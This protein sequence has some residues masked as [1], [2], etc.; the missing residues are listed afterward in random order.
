MEKNYDIFISYR[1]K[2]GAHYARILKAELEKRGYRDRVFLDYD[3]LK[4]GRF[5]RRIMDA[6]VSA[7][8]FI[9]IL[10]PGSLERCI[11]E[12]DWVRQEILYAMEKERHIIP[13]N[14]DGL[15]Q[16]FPLSVPA[17][18]KNALSQHQFTKIDSESLLNVSVDQMIKDRIAPIIA[19]HQLYSKPLGAEIVIIP[20]ADCTIYRLGTLLAKASKDT[21][22]I[23]HLLKGNHM[24]E[25]IS[26]KYPDIKEKVKITVHD[27]DYTDLIEI[28]LKDRVGRQDLE[29]QILFPYKNSVGKWGYASRE[30]KLV[31]PCLYE[32]VGFFT[33]GLASVRI[34]NLG[35]YI[36]KTGKLIIPCMYDYTYPFQGGKARVKK[37]KKYGYIDRMGKMVIPCD[38]TDISLSDTL[39]CVR[40]DGKYG[41]VDNKGYQVMPC[42]YEKVENRGEDLFIV[43]LDG[44][45]GI[46]DRKGNLIAPCIYN[47]ISYLHDGILEVNLNNKIGLIN[48]TGKFIIPCKY[49]KISY[50][51]SRISEGMVTLVTEDGWGCFDLEG[52]QIIPFISEEA[53]YFREGL[54]AITIEGKSGYID[55]TGKTV[56]PLIFDTCYAFHQG[57]AIVIQERKF[58]LI[59]KSGQMISSC[60][61][62]ELDNEFGDIEIT[63]GIYMAKQENKFGLINNTGKTIVNCVYDSITK[64]GETL[65]I[66]EKDKKYGVIDKYGNKI[67]DCKYTSISDIDKGYLKVEL[68]GK[69]GL[70]DLNGN[71]IFPT[72]FSDIYRRFGDLIETSE[73]GGYRLFDKSGHPV[74]YPCDHIYECGEGLIKLAK[75]KK[76]GLIDMKGKLVTP[77]VYNRISLF[78]E[79]LSMVKDVYDRIGYIDTNGKQVV[80]CVYQYGNGFKDGLAQVIDDFGR[81]GYVDRFGQVAIPF[82]LE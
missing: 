79:G 18:V 40:R 64:C 10:S 54:A 15:F 60:K 41:F 12:D 69:F 6:I 25:F 3:E 61:Y 56:I 27:N 29:N 7:P 67:A 8:I 4:D 24:L 35:G 49:K 21:E 43:T 44:K 74:P 76:Y 66:V 5:D 48:K 47:N 72:V 16:G 52:R 34:D 9:F 65:F 1:R 70:F 20:D 63:E 68:D 36:N 26:V 46:I 23:I 58:M 39:N 11:Y 75:G 80:P 28:H 55:R 33:E 73:Y 45:E 57:A 22:I 31:I 71:E 30:G 81:M 13:I 19:P 38:Y 77:F 82:G 2:G 42:I 62:D 78:H 51:T 53:I 32:S 50:L 14:F 17:E 59:D 37:D